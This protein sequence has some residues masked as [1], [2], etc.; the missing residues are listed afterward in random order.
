VVAEDVRVSLEL[1]G[2]LLAG[3]SLV[4][5]LTI[6]IVVLRVLQ[7]TRKEVQSGNERLEI[8]RDQQERLTFM[9]E[10]RQLILEE[11]EKRRLAISEME[12]QR[13]LAAA[14]Q[15]EVPRSWWQR[16]FGT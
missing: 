3:G 9:H 10:E 6:L 2:V 11:L 7:S 5:S 14:F 8:L 12:R 4:V 15:P 1:L 13:E 16:W